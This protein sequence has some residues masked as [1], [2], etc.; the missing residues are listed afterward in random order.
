MRLSF[1]VFVFNTLEYLA[2]A[3]QAADAGTIA[4]GRLMTLRSAAN[5]E[6]LTVRAPDGKTEVVSRTKGGTFNYADTDALGIY[7]VEEGK[8]PT[9]AFAV[10]L[11]DSV[12]SDIRPRADVKIGYVDVVGKGGTEGTRQEL[13]RPLLLAAFFI[14]L[15]EWYIY[16][17]RVYI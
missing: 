1:P 3:R 8:K 2:G 15:G 11:F 6:K 13:W 12:E 14:L 9:Q 7:Q 10:N 4:P 5:A 16:N 17:R